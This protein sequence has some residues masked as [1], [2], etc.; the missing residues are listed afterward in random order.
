MSPTLQQFRNIAVQRQNQVLQSG[1]QQQPLGVLGRFQQHQV[2]ALNGSLSSALTKTELASNQLVKQQFAQVLKKNFDGLFVLSALQQIGINSDRPLTTKDVAD[3][4][5]KGERYQLMTQN[6]INQHLNSDTFREQVQHIE[7]V[8]RED[9]G[10]F[11]E[12]L[13]NRLPLNLHPIPNLVRQNIA[14]LKT[15]VTRALLD[16]I[17]Q[18]VVNNHLNGLN[19]DLVVRDP[20]P[21]PMLHLAKLP[22]TSV[23]S[24]KPMDTNAPKLMGSM[25][26]LPKLKHQEQGF[27]FS[28]LYSSY[29]TS[30]SKAAYFDLV[31]VGHN[32]K[33]FNKETREWALNFAALKSQLDNPNLTPSQRKMIT[34]RALGYLY[35][36]A[37]V[38]NP[39]KLG[40]Q[41][42]ELC[43]DGDKYFRQG[44]SPLFKS[45]QSELE[46][47]LGLPRESAYPVFDSK[48]IDQVKRQF[49]FADKNK[50][51]FEINDLSSPGVFQEIAAASLNKGGEFFLDISPLINKIQIPQGLDGDKAAAVGKQIEDIISQ[52]RDKIRLQ[53]ETQVRLNNDDH[54][55]LREI[56]VQTREIMR[57]IMDH[58]ALGG[59]VKVGD[60][61]VMI[62]RGFDRNSNGAAVA[63]SKGMMYHGGHLLGP[64]HI[65]ESW[66]SLAPNMDSMLARL[67]KDIPELTLP[68]FAG[69]P[70]PDY[71]LQTYQGMSDFFSDP[72]VDKFLTAATHKKAPAYAQALV[73]L[74]TKQL[75]ALGRKIIPILV[76]N[77]T[78]SLA[79]FALN[80][81]S[82]HMEKALAHIDNMPA[83]L[84]DMHLVN[85][86]LATLVAL[87]EPYNPN[88]F[89]R[90]YEAE[91]G[92]KPDGVDVAPRHQF[93]NGGMHAFNAV[94][95]GVEQLTGRRDLNVAAVK[96]SYYEE[97]D[98]VLAETAHYNR[99][100]FDGS[101]VNGSVDR[102]RD[103][104]PPGKKLDLF[105]G[106][107]HHN[108]SASVQDSYKAEDLIAQ[109]NKLYE[110]DLVSDTFTV[111]I[112]T[113]IAKT[114]GPEIKQFLE[115]FADKI[116]GGEL[117][118]VFFRSGQ[119][120][121][122]GGNDNYNAGFMVAYNNNQQFG[123]F[124]A[125]SAN[126][127]NPSQG[128]VQGM[129]HIELTAQKE[130]NDY[131]KA[132]MGSH[133]KLLDPNSEL[134]LP[135]SL[136]NPDVV[137]GNES[138]LITNNEDIENTVFLDIR[139][140]FLNT[141]PK[142]TSMLAT[143]PHVAVMG[144]IEKTATSRNLTFGGRP[145]FG[146]AH[147]NT[148]LIGGQN[149]R[150]TL[151]ALTDKEIQGWG[152]V[153]QDF[154]LVGDLAISLL[155]DPKAF[156]TFVEKASPQLLNLHSELAAK[157][158]TIEFQGSLEN[159]D[160]TVD[161]KGSFSPTEVFDLATRWA[162]AGVP[163]A[164]EA[165]LAKLENA[166]KGDR[167]KMADRIH[168]KKIE[169]ASAYAGKGQLE[170]AARM[171]G[172][173][174]M[175]NDTLSQTAVA[176]LKKRAFHNHPLSAAEKKALPLLEKMVASA[177]KG[178]LAAH[179]HVVRL[180]N[181]EIEH[182]P[183]WAKQQLQGLLKNH[184]A[185]L[186]D[187][188]SIKTMDSALKYIATTGDR[189]LRTPV[190]GYI[191][192]MVQKGQK[193][194][195]DPL[196]KKFL[197]S[198]DTPRPG[199]ANA[200]DTYRQL[201]KD[202]PAAMTRNNP[203]FHLVMV[204]NIATAAV[205]EGKPQEAIA[206]VDQLVRNVNLGDPSIKSLH[207][208]R[209]A[210]LLGKMVQH[211][212]G[213]V[214]GF[215][216]VLDGSATPM[217][218]SM[219]N[220]ETVN[221]VLDHIAANYAGAGGAYD[222]L[223]ASLVNSVDK[224]NLTEVNTAL[225]AL[226]Q[227]NTNHFQQNTNLIAPLQDSVV[228][229]ALQKGDYRTFLDAVEQRVLTELNEQPLLPHRDVLK[230]VLPHVMD[231]LAM[232][233]SFIEDRLGR[234]V[235]DSDPS[236]MTLVFGELAS[237]MVGLG[238]DAE[239]RALMNKF[240]MEPNGAEA[241]Q[242]KVITELYE[243]IGKR[244]TG[245]KALFT[246]THF[247]TT[248]TI[249]G[250]IEQ[251]AP[252]AYGTPSLG[253]LRDE[254]V[255]LEKLSKMRPQNLVNLKRPMMDAYFAIAEKA[256]K[257]RDG[258]DL[259]VE[260]FERSIGHVH[261]STKDHFRQSAIHLIKTLETNNRGDLA[262]LI[263]KK[264][265]QALD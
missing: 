98:H 228:K 146:F 209:M 127:G 93:K 26:K 216:Q 111:A 20:L 202:M 83:F 135:K 172:K 96:G 154:R 254:M 251:R 208:K 213:S 68:D 145:S 27:G 11:Q 261:Q 31:K 155:K 179:E 34:S 160:L 8:I 90:L 119:K 39:G 131:R 123:D 240:L 205:A 198:L 40:W 107:F 245:S 147:A 241:N 180:V 166:N 238:R 125:G 118:V 235:S 169:L 79:Q 65:L 61:D 30:T 148:A 218:N 62:M 185:L 4:L 77:N 211:Q 78:G 174:R 94:L 112:D 3:I 85:E 234:Q 221:R 64:T 70:D 133:A 132:I 28:S 16:T 156:R 32:K 191:A 168:G 54:T 182:D 256:A 6:Q 183:T 233:S 170:H 195:V 69:F 43:R 103:N 29:K 176:V 105:L 109:V 113:T 121:D 74:V 122:M 22:K 163:Q 196:L 144:L 116:N 23:G 104:L 82:G 252:N 232:D 46:A 204:D 259:L 18:R 237:H 188:A 255:D 137:T 194:T 2:Q 263:R 97:S 71:Q 220:K 50:K 17:V 227:N 130:L 14:N 244:T 63:A 226:Y 229:V 66:A 106:E 21:Q 7:A 110:Q 92:I 157:G 52:V 102:I 257:E 58:T 200:K 37:E 192:G 201:L 265:S 9:K 165:L 53:V 117:N 100:V 222:P 225:K 49:E 158:K 75:Q 215:L 84:D 187:D 219:S 55:P 124:N 212:P 10:Y 5:T 193:G 13:P 59:T 81:M 247:G 184:G 86:E 206:A 264:A 236:P 153:F 178:P 181:R 177:P 136:R 95:S 129:M 80:R 99:S 152:R 35:K 197:L 159:D 161:L 199:L 223:L 45:F 25:T 101:D 19:T 115:A 189:S 134:A 142:G 33:P 114:D 47:G 250:Q 15:P 36:F 150:L 42:N 167:F 139:S 141:L 210:E 138:L 217:F 186:N 164:A 91:A 260:V 262:Q 108:I 246:Q 60:Q 242:A 151:G 248:A 87:T 239:A 12:P 57:N 89:G 38:S 224:S 243:Q 67:G 149:F 41:A 56:D 120:F 1:G 231:E 171:M 173:T 140:P 51:V 128:N 73:P 48:A 175:D 214:N 72:N 258:A 143:D 44:L 88:D 162:D 230:A 190:L 207:T 253:R 24:T 126:V 249:A 76:D 203:L